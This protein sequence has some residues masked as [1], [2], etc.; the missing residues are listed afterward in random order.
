[1]SPSSARSLPALEVDETD[2]GTHLRTT[3]SGQHYPVPPP[4]YGTSAPSKPHNNY[5]SNAEAQEPLLAGGSSSGAGGYYDQPGQGDIP[6]D[7]K[8][9]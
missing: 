5:F 2:C 6:D 8:V 1:M 9:K 3:M 7:F 4:S